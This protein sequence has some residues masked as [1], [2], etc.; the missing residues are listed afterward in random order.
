MHHTIEVIDLRYSY[1][2]GNAALRGVNLHVS[3]GEKAALVGPNGAGK[4]TLMLH[5]N[6][7]LVGQGEIRVCGATIAPETLGRVRA[8]VGGGVPESG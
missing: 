1:P 6:G 8:S 7:I 2:D 3:M 4:S 5:L